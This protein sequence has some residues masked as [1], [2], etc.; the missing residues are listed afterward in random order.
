VTAG[1]PTSAPCV[2]S[3]VFRPADQGV[4]ASAEVATDSRRAMMRGP[5]IHA[6]ARAARR[7]SAVAGRRG[8]ERMAGKSA[9]DRRRWLKREEV[10]DEDQVVIAL[11]GL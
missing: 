2:V 5:T 4:F 8:R 7:T 1:V 9:R 10:T 6:F 11:R 3:P